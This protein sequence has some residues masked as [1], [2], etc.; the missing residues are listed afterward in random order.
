MRS[1]VGPIGAVALELWT[2]DSGYLFDNILITRDPAVA[3]L[4]LKQ[5]WQP[6]H[7]AEVGG[8]GAVCLSVAGP[9][10]GP[11]VSGAEGTGAATRQGCVAMSILAREGVGWWG[12]KDARRFA[13]VWRLASGGERSR[14]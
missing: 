13:L 14:R 3:E 9:V 11:R 6:R 1:G 10:G 5:L 4:A 2:I 8:R 12:R 7:D